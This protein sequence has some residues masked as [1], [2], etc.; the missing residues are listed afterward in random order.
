[1][2]NIIFAILFSLFLLLPDFLFNL[3]FNYY[4]FVSKHFFKEIAIT[5]II[6]LIISYLP[7]KWKV[8][9]GAI[10]LLLEFGEIIY[11]S[12]FRSYVDPYQI[13]LIFSEYSDIIVALKSVSLFLGISIF[14]F[15]IFLIF[16]ISF[17]TNTN[18]KSIVLLLILLVAFPLIVAKKKDNYTP[19]PTHFSY[20][21][22][23]FA[24][25]L[26]LINSI[27]KT[28]L[29]PLKSYNIVKNDTQKKIVVL[30]IGESLNYKRMHLFGWDLNNTPHLDNLKKDKNFIY[31]KTFSSG[32]NTPI[33]V[34]S[35]IDIKREPNYISD[36]F[37]LLKLAKDNHYK[38]Y[39]FSMQEEGDRI[40]VVSRFA[41]V[42]KEKDS[43]KRKYDD[44]LLKDLKNV[45]FSKKSFIILHFRANHAPYEK[46]TPS[47]FYKW[48]FDYD[49]YHKK[50]Y[51]AYM[52]SVL[53][54]DKV[55]SDI[56]NYMKNNHKNFSLYFMSDHAEML[57]FKDE[58]GKYGHSK[59]DINVATIPFIYYSDKADKKFDKNFY[60]QYL[61]SKMIANDLGYKIINPNEKGDLYYINN[62]R[63]D[64]SA[65]W[66]EYNLSN[67]FKTYKKVK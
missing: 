42:R 17:K 61:I 33:A 64:G 44:E 62:V 16:I 14:L 7:K 29:P 1:M 48:K 31:K 54:V 53:Y 37:N 51:F 41:E 49:D 39:W 5:F 3:Y 28:P 34:A 40:R 19:N 26:A 13:G 50:Q 52:D 58:N 8:V 11:F 56:I 18:K 57:G 59:L 30:I 22:N 46:Y 6:S 15:I 38:T 35:I 10:F 2:S 27:H 55:L 24:F 36:K 67:P 25:N 4:L 45:D 20:L 63:L 21:N 60:N 23:F 65:G 43:Y 47:S 66:I 9:F 12:Y 32:V